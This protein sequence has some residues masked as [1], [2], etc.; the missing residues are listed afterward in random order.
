MRVTFCFN[1]DDA[2]VGACE[3]VPDQVVTL[4]SQESGQPGPAHVDQQ[5]AAQSEVAATS[6][7]TTTMED[8]S[9]LTA[10]PLAAVPPEPS[11]GGGSPSGAGSTVS[12]PRSEVK[13]Q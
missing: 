1:L 6:S 3:S 4:P 5:P 11:L 13:R 7:D 10:L 12:T 2:Y 9:A 8:M